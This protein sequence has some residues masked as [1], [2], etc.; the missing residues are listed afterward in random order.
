MP[1]LVKRTHT[2]LKY[3]EGKEARKQGSKEARKQGSKEASK[4]VSKEA[5]KQGSK[6]TSEKQVSKLEI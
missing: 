4:Q 3:H 2:R 6:E 5:R 1:V